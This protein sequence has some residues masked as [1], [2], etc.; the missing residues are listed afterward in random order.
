MALKLASAMQQKGAQVTLVL[1]LEGVRLVSTQQPQDLRWGTG[2]TIAAHY[3]AFV[4]GGGRVL[5]CPHCAKAAGLDEKNLR[6]GAKIVTEEALT[7][8]LLTADKIL[9]Y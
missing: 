6:A 7:G 1:D 2:E 4:K 5:V 3:D 8:A 9:D